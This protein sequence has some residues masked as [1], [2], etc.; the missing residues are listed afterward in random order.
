MIAAITPILILAVIVFA[1][2]LRVD[3]FSAFVEG[4]GEALPMLKKLVPCMASIMLAIAVFRDSGALDFLTNFLAPAVEPLGLDARLLPLLLVR[5][6]SG[7]AA[8]AAATEIFAAHGPDSRVGFLASILVGASE[9]I[10]YTI[11]LYFGAVGVKKTRFAIPVAL[12]AMLAAVASGLLFGKMF[13][14]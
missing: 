4:A 7:S 13:Y 1:A 6:F 8:I 9:T 12:A 11:A 10:F 2:V 3:V 14:K 5:P